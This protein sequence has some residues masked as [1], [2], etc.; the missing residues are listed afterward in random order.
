MNIMNKLYTSIGLMSGTSADGIDASIIQSDGENEL[1][2]INDLFLPYDEKIRSDIKILKEKVNS[3]LN[4]I[5]FKKD[6]INL[7]KKLTFLNAKAVELVLKTSKIKRENLDIIGYHGQTIYHS[8]KDKLSKQLGDGKLLSQLSQSNLVYNFR[9]NDIK[10]GGQ[11]A[12]L[13]PIYHKLIYKKFKI[14][15][16]VFFVNIGGIS[17]L[18]FIDQDKLI[19]FDSGPGNVLN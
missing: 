9:A 7:E 4:L 10:N 12:P 15:K 18:T 3:S 14:D 13:T 6:L 11:G 16:P 17:N 19:S 2:L 5:T 8:F 1:V